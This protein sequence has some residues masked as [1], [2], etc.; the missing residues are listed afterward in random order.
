MAPRKRQRPNPSSSDSKTDAPP[1]PPQA[2]TSKAS[3]PAT[4]TTS[5]PVSQPSQT[6]RMPS[7]EGTDKE[8]TKDQQAA[9]G[10]TKLV[11][12]SIASATTV[13]RCPTRHLQLRLAFF[14]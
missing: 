1:P 2:D 9:Q 10:S 3:G 8:S 14:S 5:L 13:S 4:S 6:E 11:C 12:F 7:N